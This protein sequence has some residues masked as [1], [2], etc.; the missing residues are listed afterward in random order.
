MEILV[1]LIYYL[2]FTISEF[3]L[4]NIEFLISFNY[5]IALICFYF[6]F[7]IIDVFIYTFPMQVYFL[8]NAIVSVQVYT[9]FCRI[10]LWNNNGN[11]WDRV[12][13]RFA[14]NEND[15]YHL[16]TF[17]F[18]DCMITLIISLYL[19]LYLFSLRRIN[20]SCAF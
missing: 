14:N 12:L 15:F 13:G 20:A 4:K 8:L 3:R 5:L 10:Y 17:R 1:S 18:Y 9:F 11:M 16:N 7:L 2:F 19:F 6:V